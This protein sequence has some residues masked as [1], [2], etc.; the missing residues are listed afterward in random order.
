MEGT[1]SAELQESLIQ[2]LAEVFQ[3][4]VEQVSPDLSFGDL[5][6]WDSL[7]HM[8]LL[9]SLEARYDL[10]VD[11]DMIAELVTF[12]A[13]VNYIEAHQDSSS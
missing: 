12:Q 6:G 5:P 9:A 13:I 2:L 10:E 4:P 7:G 1:D 11:T 3:E 8:N